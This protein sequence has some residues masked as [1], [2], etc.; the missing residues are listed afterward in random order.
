MR[1]KAFLLLLPLLCLP[2][3]SKSEPYLPNADLPFVLRNGEAILSDSA[4]Y[5]AFMQGQDV[6]KAVSEAEQTG[7]TLLFFFHKEDCSYCEDVKEG[8]AAFEGEYKAKVLSYTNV[9][10]PNYRDVVDAFSTIVPK[11]DKGFFNG[12]G[13]PML[14][15]Y[16][17][18]SLSKIELYGNHKSLRTVEKLMTGL[19]SFPYL[20]EFSLYSS[21]SPF[22]AK[23]YPLYLLDSGETLPSYLTNNLQKSAKSFGLLAKSNLSEEEIAS[24]EEAYGKET[25]I[26]S[27]GGIIKKE[28]CASFCADY[29]AS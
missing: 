27:S 15:S 26:I 24:L 28:G 23:G 10:S 7:E 21:I 6:K 5:D 19:Y 20:Y 9:T 25:K 13:T 16:K 4:G 1:K 22:L 12:F 14:F 8:F 18:G 3:C 29:F 11:S 17:D 2:S